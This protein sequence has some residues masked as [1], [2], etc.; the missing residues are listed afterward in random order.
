MI[1]KLEL[2][3]ANHDELIDFC[4]AVGIKFLS[5]AFDIESLDFLRKECLDYIKIPSGELTNLPLLREMASA[6]LP[7]IMST[8]MAS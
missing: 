1:E 4:K 2:S 8:G 5:T 6:D 7:I 3:E